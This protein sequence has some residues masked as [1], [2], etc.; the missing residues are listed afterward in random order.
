MK[1][2][3]HLVS[4]DRISVIAGNNPMSKTKDVNDPASV[5]AF[6][7]Q[8]DDNIQRL[9][10]DI[11]QTILSVDKSIGEQIKWNSPSFFYTGTMKPFNPKEYKRDIAVFNIRKGKI[12]LV[13]PTGA[14]I[15]DDS[16]VL[17]G[18]Y[19][20]GRRLINIADAADLARKKDALQTVIRKWLQQVE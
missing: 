7:Q 12:M 6:I 8:L 20:D 1:V 9:A 13:L 18:N 10:E 17:E 2:A 5:T 16:G 11:R 3:N 15:S 14:T 4:I 19:T